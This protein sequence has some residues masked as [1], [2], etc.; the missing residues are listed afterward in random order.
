MNLENKSISFFSKTIDD[1]KIT[2][3][4]LKNTVKTLG[5]ENKKLEEWVVTDKFNELGC[6]SNYIRA[7][8]K[9]QNYLKCLMYDVP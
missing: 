9:H 7:K 2:T 8:I 4:R 6:N 3:K 5:K 1:F